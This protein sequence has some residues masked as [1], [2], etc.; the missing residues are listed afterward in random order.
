LEDTLEDTFLTVHF[1]VREHFLKWYN[2]LVH[3]LL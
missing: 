1:T 3:P 2:F